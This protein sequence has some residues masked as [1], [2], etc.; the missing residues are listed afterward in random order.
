MEGHLDELIRT[1]DKK[2]AKLFPRLSN[3][4]SGQIN[5]DEEETKETIALNNTNM[6]NSFRDSR[7]D[8]SLRGKHNMSST[9]MDFPVRETLVADATDEIGITGVE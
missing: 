3:H 6:P 9:D 4:L 7:I 2:A 1:Q 8:N 5:D